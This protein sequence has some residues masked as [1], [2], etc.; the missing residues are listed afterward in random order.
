MQFIPL[1]LKQGQYKAQASI[2]NYRVKTSG[3]HRLFELPVFDL[4]QFFSVTDSISFRGPAA[5]TNLKFA[6]GQG[7]VPGPIER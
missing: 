4:L 5:Q 2:G 6:I 3:Q 1:S 7:D